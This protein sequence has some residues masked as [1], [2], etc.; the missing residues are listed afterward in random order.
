MW[1]ALLL[2]ALASPVT[3]DRAVAAAPPLD[4]EA[5]AAE[6]RRL[7]QDIRQLAAREAWVGVERKF[8]ELVAL[9][10]PLTYE[11]W[12]RGAQAARSLGRVDE[13][14]LRLQAAAALDPTREALDWLYAIDS[15]YGH[16]SLRAEPPLGVALRVAEMPFD[17]DARLAVEWAVAEVGRAAAFEGLLPRGSYDFAA[18]PFV[19]EPGV[20]VQIDVNLRRRRAPSD[21]TPPAV[22]APPQEMQE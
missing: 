21:P 1:S 19:V 17:P 11:D 12:W 9:G 14:Y 5:A 4:P 3:S 10:V 22:A 20:S 7:A 6:G 18:H 2:P 8:Q 15:N 16:V 13:V